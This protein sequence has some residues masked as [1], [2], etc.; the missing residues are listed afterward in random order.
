MWCKINSP[1]VCNNMYFW[2]ITNCE[3]LN[4]FS[5]SY[6]E[7]NIFFPTVDEELKIIS[8]SISIFKSIGVIIIIN[9]SDCLKLCL[10]KYATYN[11]LKTK[12]GKLEILFNELR[13]LSPQEA[14]KRGYSL[15]RK[16]KKILNSINDISVSDKLQLILSDGKC[17]AKI[18]EKQK[19]IIITKEKKI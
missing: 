9:N 2:G 14:L 13:E 15:I 4:F 6:H 10:D 1:L 11:I 12:R 7:I 19:N 17:L 16:E 8:E 18:I 3:H 5:L